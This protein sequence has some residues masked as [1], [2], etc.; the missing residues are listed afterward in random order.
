M[1]ESGEDYSL[2]FPTSPKTPNTYSPELERLWR[3]TSHL[4]ADPSLIL[5]T[6]NVYEQAARLKKLGVVDHLSQFDINGPQNITDELSKTPSA[7]SLSSSSSTCSSDLSPPAHLVP[8]QMHHHYHHHHHPYSTTTI[9]SEVPYQHPG[10]KIRT[11]PLIHS[12]TALL[13]C[14]KRLPLDNEL[15]NEDL[16]PTTTYENFMQKQQR[17]STCYCR[18]HNRPTNTTLPCTNPIYY[19]T[20]NTEIV[21]TEPIRYSSDYSMDFGH[22]LYDDKTL[23]TTSSDAYSSSL[24]IPISLPIDNTQSSSPSSSS[25]P[26]YSLTSPIDRF[27]QT[28]IN[29]MWSSSIVP[30]G[31]KRSSTNTSNGP[32]TKRKASCSLQN[33]NTDED[34]QRNHTM[35]HICSHP[36]CGKIYNKSS[37]LRAHERTH[38]G[39]KPYSCQWPACGWKFARS[40]EL[41]RHY[42]KHTGVKP[43]PCKFCDRAFARSDHLTLHMK[44]HL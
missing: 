23:S 10:S 4:R 12:P 43:F 5:E 13:L 38:T 29:D 19:N 39:I 1:I 6:P 18:N 8:F 32:K 20:N 40:D 37:H 36:G 44:R 33:N 42:R 17:L 41:T 35:T 14:R 11:S 27:N 31:R 24:L 28:G 25:I 21:K 15:V 30:K 7:M 9:A 16:S 26:D 3:E 34:I 22:Q 2:G